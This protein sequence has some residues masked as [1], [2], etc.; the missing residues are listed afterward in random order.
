MIEP[1][2]LSIYQ[3]GVLSRNSSMSPFMSLRVLDH[4][5]SLLSPTSNRERKTSEHSRR[6]AKS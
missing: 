3:G 5:Q 4:H 2:A 6:R 1:K